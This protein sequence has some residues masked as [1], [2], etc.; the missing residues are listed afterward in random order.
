MPLLSRF[1]PHPHHDLQLVVRMSSDVW[2][3]G[4]GTHPG[5]SS[6]VGH[7]DIHQQAVLGQC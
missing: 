1:V 6:G 3:L 4:V 2:E 5:S 7:S